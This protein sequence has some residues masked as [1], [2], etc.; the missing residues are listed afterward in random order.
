MISDEDGKPYLEE[1]FDHTARHWTNP[2]LIT[3]DPL[4]DDYAVEVKVKP[5]SLRD[6]AGIAFRYHTNRH[7]Y[8]VGLSG[9]NKVTVMLRQPFELQVRKKQTWKEIAS[10]PFTY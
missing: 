3:G 7:Y 2:I 8:A 4:W 9:G 5:L 6:M 1:Q 10:A